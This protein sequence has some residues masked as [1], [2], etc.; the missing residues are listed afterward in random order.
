MPRERRALPLVALPILVAAGAPTGL[1]PGLWRISSTP[2]AATLDGR[3]LA[4]LPYDAPPPE[5]VCLSAPDAADPARW[6][7]RDSAPGCRWSRRSVAGGRV[8]MKGICPA[9]EPGQPPGS[10]RL[11]GRWTATRYDIRFA[12]VAH[13]SNGRMGLDGATT[14][15]RIGECPRLRTQ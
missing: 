13:G 15:V 12:T 7:T 2:A 6:F 11:T 14:G 8:S 4:D 10:T 3:R 5:E 9:K 1:E